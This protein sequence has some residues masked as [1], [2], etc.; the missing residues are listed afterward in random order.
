MSDP[1]D[2][3]GRGGAGEV[4]ADRKRSDQAS[5]ASGAADWARV[6]LIV[7]GRVQGV[8]Y[9]AAAADQ[10]RALALGGWARN[11]ADGTVEIVAEG[12]RVGLAQ[13]AAW[14]RH[15]PPHARVDHVSEERGEFADEFRE[16]K[17]R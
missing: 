2:R 8:C 13:F 15:G 1:P 3:S 16:F 12:R 10:A 5:P 7:A 9:R 6:R 14:A 4:H 11:L 17:V